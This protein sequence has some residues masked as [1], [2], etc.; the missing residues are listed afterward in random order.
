MK[1][2]KVVGGGGFL[3]AG[4]GGLLRGLFRGRVDL[5]IQALLLA[6]RLYQYPIVEA[7]DV[8][9]ASVNGLHVG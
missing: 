7:L 3:L 4:D 1:I 6:H 5:R 9:A 2:S 8:V